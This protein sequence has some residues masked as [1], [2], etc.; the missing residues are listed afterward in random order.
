MAD[1]QFDIT[2]DLLSDVQAPAGAE[3]VNKG[4]VDPSRVEPVRNI[5]KPAQIKDAQ[6]DEPKALSLRDQISSALKGEPATPDA[7]QQD[8]GQARGPDGKF[9]P[10]TPEALAAEAAVAA[11]APA[12]VPVPPAPGLTPEVFAT[13]PAETQA[14][15]ARTME[16]VGAQQAQLNAYNNIEQVIGPRR[17]AWGLNG[18]TDVQAVTQLFALSDFAGKDPE[19]FIRYFAQQNRLDLEEIAFGGE[20]VDPQMQAL[21]QEIAQ[22]RGNLNGMTAQQQQAAHTNTVNQIIGFFEAKDASGT[23]LRPHAD[24]IGD[25]LMPFVNAERQRNPNAPMEQVLQ[26]AYDAASWATPSVRAKLQQASATADEATRLAQNVDKV[27]AAKRAGAS[28]PSGVSVAADTG[29]LAEGG[30]L[31]DTIR[32]SIAANS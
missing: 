2:S 16:Q 22:L 6:N 26:A 25:N 8:G 32:A 4:S 7:A 28:I 18:M 5:E 15:L 21:Q 11:P 14:H 24:E 3:S 1:E 19:G 27:A 13:L 9:V 29:K 30:S 31:R 17:Q 23:P 12:V 20:P 10:K